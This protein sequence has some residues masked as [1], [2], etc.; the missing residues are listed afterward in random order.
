MRLQ[1]NIKTRALQG[2]DLARA[3]LAEALMRVEP[4]RVGRATRTAETEVSVEGLGLTASAR[5]R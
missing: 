1:N 2:D 3:M 5:S 4:P